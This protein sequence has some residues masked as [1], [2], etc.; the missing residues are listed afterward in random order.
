[1]RSLT[2]YLRSKGPLFVHQWVAAD[3]SIT[4][5]VEQM[6]A[7]AKAEGNTRCVSQFEQWLKW[8]GHPGPEQRQSGIEAEPPQGGE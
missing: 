3:D 2:D 6:L 1:M 8:D 4:P 5:D 7:E